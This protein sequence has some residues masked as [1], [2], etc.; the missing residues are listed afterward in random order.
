MMSAVAGSATE[1]FVD[2]PGFDRTAWEAAVGGSLTTEDFGVDIAQADTLNHPSGLQSVAAGGFD[3][4]NHNVGDG[5]LNMHLRTSLASVKG[6]LTITLHFPYPVTAFGAD[7]YSIGGSREVS[8]QGVFDSGSQA[9]GLRNL[10]IADGGLDQGFFGLKS[11]VPFSSITLIAL[12]SILS[13]DSFNMDNVAFTTGVVSDPPKITN[14]SLL[15]STSALI[16][17][18]GKPNTA[19]S[20][21]ASSDIVSGFNTAVVPT[22]GSLTTNGSGLGVVAF[23]VVPGRR[24]LRIEE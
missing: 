12:G 11:T 9:F 24:F 2:A 16:I 8:V 23:S 15:T 19:Y 22:G 17:F 3:S 7:F 21:K 5:R 4:P 1:I 18:E 6:Y 10:F 20:L 14:I 13:N